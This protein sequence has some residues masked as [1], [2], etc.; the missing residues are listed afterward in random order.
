MIAHVI[1]VLLFLI[2]FQNFIYQYC[3]NINFLYDTMIRVHCTE[4]NQFAAALTGPR[5]SSPAGK[6][7]F[8]IGCRGTRGG[9]PMNKNTGTVK[10][11]RGVRL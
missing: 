6:Q 7:A 4:K 2:E 1:T 10:N 8:S 3:L 5:K 11:N 9:I